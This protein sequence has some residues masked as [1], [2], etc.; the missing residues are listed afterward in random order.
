MTKP[1]LYAVA[2]QAF[3][4]H[5]RRLAL[6]LACMA[7]AA[8]VASAQGPVC[9]ACLALEIPPGM[10][11]ALPVRL[12]GLEVLV[13]VAAGAERTALGALAEISSRG[14]RPGL[15]VTGLPSE[16]VAAD[17]LAATGRLLIDLGTA[18]A[19]DPRQ[20]AF[21]LKTQSTAAR[22]GG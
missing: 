1:P 4:R 10:V 9:A 5:R 14:G 11:A 8:G 21:L 16:G 15:V 6:V 12:E 17:V 18:P 22:A 3:Y 20:T 13:R 19:G 7:L 2:G